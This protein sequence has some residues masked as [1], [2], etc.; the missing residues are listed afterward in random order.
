MSTPLFM[1]YGN[2]NNYGNMAGV[3]LSQLAQVKNNP[4][5]VLDILGVSLKMGR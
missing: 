2:P 1:K 5:Y 4:G 3:I